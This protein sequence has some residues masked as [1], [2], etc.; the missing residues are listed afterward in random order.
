MF[1]FNPEL[2][3]GDA[4]TAA[5]LLA[6]FFG[7]WVSSNRFR[8]AIEQ[9]HKAIS[10]AYYAELDR[11][12]NDLLAHVITHPTLRSPKS[13]SD[14]DVLRGMYE[15]FPD[16]EHRKQYDA[17]AHMVWCFVE[18]VHDRCAACADAEEKQTLIDI[19]RT[20]IDAENRVHRGWFLNEMR[21]E[22]VRQRQGADVADIF[23]IGFRVFVFEKQWRQ[24]DWGYRSTFSDP[25]DFQISSGP[26]ATLQS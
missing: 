13:F 14:D 10:S 7:G 26:S 22:A 19:W 2:S 4:I 15:P 1:K 8:R 20:A 18:T 9:N 24:G 21:E 5:A 16:G 23:N 12:Y 17:Y 11:Y 3:V 6:V 25:P